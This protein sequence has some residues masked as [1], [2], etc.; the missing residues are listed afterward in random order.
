M[1]DNTPQRCSCGESMT[2]LVSLPQLAII[3]IDNRGMLVNTLNE[4]E[5]AYEFPGNGKY[6]KRY[7]SVVARS[8]TKE[9]PKA[10]F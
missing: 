6:D 3:A 9:R 5:K 8:L 1:G 10:F 4:D 7:K 2:K